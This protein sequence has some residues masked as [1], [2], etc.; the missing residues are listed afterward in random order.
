MKSLKFILLIAIGIMIIFVACQKETEM[1]GDKTNSENSNTKQLIDR[2]QDFRLLMN[3]ELKSGTSTN[4]DSVVW[5]LEALITYDYGYPDSVSGDFKLKTTEH[6]ITVDTNYMASTANVQT[7][8][9]QML[10]S[11]NYYLNL[12][13]S[14]VKFVVFTDV[15]LKEING[16]TATLLAIT[17]YGIDT[18]HAYTPF[19]EGDDWIWGATS[20]DDPPAGGCN[21]NEDEGSDGSD[22]LE[23]RLNDPDPNEPPIATDIMIT[24]IETI[25]VS[26]MSCWYNEP[27]NLARVFKIEGEAEY[28]MENEE[29]TYYLGN[30]DW[31]IYDYNDPSND[32]EWTVVI[33]DGEGARPEGKVFLKIEIEDNYITHEG[34]TD[35]FH[36]YYITYGKHTNMYSGQ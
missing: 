17:G 29:L 12:Y 34:V 24:D 21:G 8:Y 23:W 2:I 9:N 30:G 16:T 13:N 6:S 33:E 4:I 5:N 15:E 18:Y 1:N 27:P 3:S 14:N 11:N 19:G 25:E 32:Y 7:V 10:D 28:C 26:F 20:P 36:R 22:E 35:W 31:I